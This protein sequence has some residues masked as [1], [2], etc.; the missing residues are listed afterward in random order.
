MNKQ[1]PKLTQQYVVTFRKYLTNGREA[2]LEEAYELGRVAIASGLGVLDMARIHEEAIKIL[3]RPLLVLQG[4][5]Q[6][7]KAKEIFFLETLSP[8]EATHRG[9]REINVK[10]Q[11]RNLELEREIGEHKRTEKA[12]RESENHF[13]ELFNRARRME[14]NLRSLSNKIL[15]VQEEER[16]RISRELHDE[17]SQAM[18]AVSI[19]IGALKNN[20]AGS[21]EKFQSRNCGYAGPVAADDGNRTS[22]CPRVAARH[23]GRVG[24]AARA[25][26]LSTET[27][28][29][30]PHCVLVFAAIPS[31]KNWVP[32]KK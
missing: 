13:R 8:F 10:L 2:V 20:G 4:H 1:I 21:H 22:F 19:N 16:K 18:T 26:M 11:E 9:F 23:A 32:I 28:R 24:F 30:E 15:H 12:L 6:V 17:I 5:E 3:L 14:E 31:P 29:T 27:L 25:A 7:L